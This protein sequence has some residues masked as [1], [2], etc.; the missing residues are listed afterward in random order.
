MSEGAAEA[1]REAV[2]AIVRGGT[3]PRRG[4]GDA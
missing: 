4:G 3:E 2:E 1:V